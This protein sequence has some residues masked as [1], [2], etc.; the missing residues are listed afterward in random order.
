MGTCTCWYDELFQLGELRPYCIIFETLF[1]WEGPNLSLESI[2]S[3]PRES[4]WKSDPSHS[5]TVY[6]VSRVAQYT[7]IGPRGVP[8]D[9]VSANELMT[10]PDRY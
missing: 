9:R 10:V 1:A 6:N 8:G 3:R 5:R 2:Y 4:G 7:N